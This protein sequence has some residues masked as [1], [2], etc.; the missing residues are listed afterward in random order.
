MCRGPAR[1]RVCGARRAPHLL[2]ASTQL[3]VDQRRALART[4]SCLRV[5]ADRLCSCQRDARLPPVRHMSHGSRVVVV[6]VWL[7]WWRAVEGKRRARTASGGRGDL[8]D[9]PD[10]Q[11]ERQ[12]TSTHV[13]RTRVWVHYQRP[14]ASDLISKEQYTRTIYKHYIIVIVYLLVH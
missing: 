2:A 1:N 14:R 6:I 5:C 7:R 10:P 12:R 13:R 11:P 3:A 9:G 8:P 4:R